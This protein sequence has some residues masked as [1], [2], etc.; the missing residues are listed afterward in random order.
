MK[1]SKFYTEERA[2]LL[3]QMES[4]IDLAKT[5]ERELTDDENVKFDEMDE[6]AS[7]LQ[8]KAERALKM[9][10]MKKKEV[11]NVVSEEEKVKRSYSFLKHIDGIINNNLEGAEKEVQEQAQSE[12]RSTGRSI[13]G[14]GIPASMFEKRADVT[15]NIAGTSVEAFVDAIREDA[16]YTQ[17]GADFLNLTGDARIPIVNKQSTAWMAAEN[18]G[19]ADGGAAFSSVTLSPNRIAGYVN[20]SKELIHQ[21]GTGVERAIMADLG[22]SV[23]EN[24]ADAMFSAST[25]TN[26]P[27]S[28]P[29]TTDV[30]TFTET[31]TF[32]DAVSMF[33]DLVLAEETLAAGEGLSGNLAYVLH[34]TFLNQLKRAAQVS[35]VNPAMDGMNYQQ[36]MVNGY[37]VF[38]SKHCG[39]V[40]D[41]SADG[42]FADFSNVK[43]G[44][45]GGVDVVVDPYTV[46]VNNQIRLVVNTL[47]D[48]KLAQGGKAVK[49]TSLLA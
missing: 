17:L 9:E 35:G 30:L 19:A 27:T 15:S 49:F 5:E 28:I 29:A 37:K 25:V 26:A 7:K 3:E 11:R 39:A 48:F 40:A 34:P 14:A 33:K 20:I 41:T 1:S 31:G 6:Q 47:V 22:K 43:V 46:A 45:F 13:Q 18:T 38:Y 16:I 8:S 10:E 23:S 24:I 42:I 44:M 36:Q 32:A 2:S 21:N 12:A 4:L